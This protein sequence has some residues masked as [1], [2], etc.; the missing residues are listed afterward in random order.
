MGEQGH[1]LRWK[2]AGTHAVWGATAYEGRLLPRGSGPRA[3]P[4]GSLG[5]R[6]NTES[7]CLGVGAV[8][9]REFGARDGVMFLSVPMHGIGRRNGL[10]RCKEQLLSLIILGKRPPLISM[11]KRRL[12]VE[13]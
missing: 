5:N 1:G 11:L 4:S 12:E 10:G 13:W 8:V 6:S 9:W 3:P 7:E 2:G